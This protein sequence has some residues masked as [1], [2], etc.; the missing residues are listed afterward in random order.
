[1]RH[2]TSAPEE[3]EPAEPRERVTVAARPAN[4]TTAAFRGRGGAR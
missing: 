3:P 2:L 4:T 1:M